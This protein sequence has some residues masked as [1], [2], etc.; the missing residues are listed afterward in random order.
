MRKFSLCLA[1]LILAIELHG[2]SVLAATADL[3]LTIS[4][5]VTGTTAPANQVA[6]GDTITYTFALSNTGPAAAPATVVTL[7]IPANTTLVSA[8]QLTGPAIFSQTNVGAPVTMVTFS[9]GATSYNSGAANDATF[10]LAVRVN[11]GVGSGMTITENASA[12][13][14]AT[15]PAGNDT[16]TKALTT[17][18]NS[19][20]SVTNSASATVFSTSK[21]VT[22]TITVTNNGPTNATGVSFSDTMAA[23]TQFLSLSQNSGP[24]FTLATPAV[25][26]NGPISGTL[27]AMNAG[28]AATFSLVIRYPA[29]ITPPANLSNVVSVT[30]T[31]QDLTGGNNSAT[32]AATVAVTANMGVV[33]SPSPSPVLPS[34]LLT[35]TCTV[36]NNGPNPAANAS[37]AF[38]F[39]NNVSFNS[40][41]VPAGWIKTSTN[42]AGDTTGSITAT[43]ASMPAVPAVGSSAAFVITFAVDTMA[44][45]AN[46]INNT[47]TVGSTT[48]E[49]QPD[50]TPNT[51]IVSVPVQL[52]H[53]ILLSVLFVPNGEVGIA[54]GSHSI[55]ASGGV[56]PITLAVTNVVNTTG[57]S[58]TGS[59]TGTVTVSG[60][61][62]SNGDV[63]F[64]VT[65][66]DSIGP[67]QV[68]IYTFV[69]HFAPVISPVALPA[70]LVGVDYGENDITVSAVVIDDNDDDEDVVSDDVFVL[71]VSA[72][73]NTTGLSIT[74]SGTDTITV[75]G[76]AT[77]TGTVTFTVTPSGIFGANTA[78]AVNFSIPVTFEIPAFTSG[79]TASPNP[80]VV[81]LTVMFSA[82][83]TPVNAPI[84]WNFGDGSPAATGGSVEHTYI[85]AGS[86]TVTATAQNPLG[87]GTVTQT[88]TQTVTDAAFLPGTNQIKITQGR[89]RLYSSALSL[90]GTVPFPAGTNFSGSFLRLSVNGF[91]ETFK[92]N[93]VGNVSNTLGTL[94]IK[95]YRSN[96]GVANFTIYLHGGNFGTTLLTQNTPLDAQGRPTKALIEIK[97]NGLVGSYITPL[98]Y[99]SPSS[100]GLAKFGQK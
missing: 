6:V 43:L 56:G 49:P 79:P 83:A 50:P 21:D 84:T 16:P 15:N 51:A 42:N 78:A 98:N 90:A 64:T 26:G 19:D 66:S 89:I 12:T 22:Y 14:T 93:S 67:G 57:L 33:V 40:V 20:M 1:G 88:F 65:S 36:T 87:G 10:Q 44:T 52:P 11:Q 46:P 58:I 92:L 75:S 8:T 77:S 3:M 27:A 54:Y 74:G 82:A 23:G 71:I 29:T 99:L 72:L 80:S 85:V 63:S 7:N 31:T 39:P 61:P 45:P 53:P 96:P 97:L 4:N 59:G 9:S 62:T 28:A 13:T 38:P 73:T 100:P 17:I 24:A 37:F 81:F 86:Y 34:T 95:I 35:Y 47:V 94:R 76:T 48:V 25:N 91:S 55:T 70:A 5:T 41:A 18:I 60:T 69:V 68:G 32:A 30:S 2:P